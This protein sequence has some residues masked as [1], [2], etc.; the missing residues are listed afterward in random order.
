MKA[1]IGETIKVNKTERHMNKSEEKTTSTVNIYTHT[2]IKL[3]QQETQYPTVQKPKQN[4]KKKHT[5]RM[6]INM[7]SVL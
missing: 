3:Q 1:C 7:I 5:H 4:L 6:S 2:T